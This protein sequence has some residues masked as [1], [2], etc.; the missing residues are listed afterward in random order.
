MIPEILPEEIRSA[1][2]R[3]PVQ[4]RQ[5]VLELRFRRDRPVT[6]VY[7]RGEEVLP[8]NIL[9]TGLVLEE[10]LDRATGFSP[11]SLKLEETGLYLPVTGGCRLGL[12]GETVI[13]NGQIHGLRQISSA[14]L[15]FA[16]AVWG[17]AG[18]A[19]DKLMEGG[20]MA[21]ALIVSPPGGGKTTFLRDL[22]RIV[23]ERGFRVSVAD[24]RREISAMEGGAVRL[25]LGPCTD[26]LCG[27]PKERAI[28]LLVRAM[29][30]QVIAV[31]ELAG[32]EEAEAAL[33]AA[34]SGVAVLA[35][36]HGSGKASLMERSLYRKLLESG[37]FTW[38]IYPNREGTATM[39][40]VGTYDEVSGCH[41]CGGCIHDGR[42]GGQAEHQ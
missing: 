29:N 1:F 11:Y 10:L 28:P 7:S 8:G 9:V 22:I 36:V 14:S 41:I 24:E 21:S 5:T 25:D 39:E 27:C 16:R 23:S 2:E 19:A 3:I 30:P 4:K 12:C 33:Y 20:S 6:A 40:R 32:E 18:A 42:A 26:V 17:I 13:R 31:D 15:R 35:T 34:F 37:G 38:L